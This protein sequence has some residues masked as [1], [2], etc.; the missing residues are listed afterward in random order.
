[1][2]KIFK[3]I[4]RIDLDEY[5]Q[6]IG[7][8][9]GFIDGSD[10][11]LESNEDRLVDTLESLEAAESSIDKT[12]YLDITDKEAILEYEYI[13]GSELVYFNTVEFMG[14]TYP[15]T[16]DL[17]SEECWQAIMDFLSKTGN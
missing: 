6:G 12:L 9:P 13:P 8:N 16:S 10:S 2:E 14:K 15:I 7:D 11:F 17:F 4:I 5:I 1:M 3:A